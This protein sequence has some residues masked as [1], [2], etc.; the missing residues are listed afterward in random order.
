M[1]LIAR[2]QGYRQGT[3][4]RK[5][6]RTP[7][8]TNWKKWGLCFYCANILHPEE[9]ENIPRRGTG[10]KYLHDGEITQS[11]TEAIENKTL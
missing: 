6:T 1:L 5:V 10:G 8:A 4:C 9:Y 2:C 3:D 7:Y 11:M